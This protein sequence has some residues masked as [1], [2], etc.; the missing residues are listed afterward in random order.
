MVIHSVR[1]CIEVDTSMALLLIL[2]NDVVNGIDN[3]NDNDNNIIIIVNG[4]PLSLYMNQ[5]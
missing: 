3:E 5:C 1:K 4:D 2:H